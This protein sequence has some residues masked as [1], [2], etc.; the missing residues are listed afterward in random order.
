MKIR[1]KTRVSGP[2]ISAEPGQVLDLP[3]EQAQPFIDGHYAEVVADV[4]VKPPA[5]EPETRPSQ[6][7]PETA[8]TGPGETAVTDEPKPRKR[9]RSS[10]KS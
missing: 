1:M 4:E 9:R 3:I 5:V 6:D 10:A 8:S 2:T 7:E